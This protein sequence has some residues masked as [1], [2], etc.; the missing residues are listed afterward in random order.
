MRIIRLEDLLKEEM[1]PFS[2]KLEGWALS[3]EAVLCAS[4]ICVFPV[5]SK[6]AHSV[7]GAPLVE[8]GSSRSTDHLPL[9]FRSG[10]LAPQS[11]H[12]MSGLEE[13][14]NSGSPHWI[15]TGRGEKSLNDPCSSQFYIV[16]YIKEASRSTD[17]CSFFLALIQKNSRQGPLSFPAAWLICFPWNPSSMLQYAGPEPL[18]ASPQATTTALAGWRVSCQLWN[19]IFW[20]HATS[21]CKIKMHAISKQNG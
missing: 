13:E 14:S 1:E 7:H 2:T 5:T 12:A 11:T 21:Q 6:A 4:I 19:I 10:F 16:D 20:L 9:S 3:R 18:T 15:T 17:G 8:D